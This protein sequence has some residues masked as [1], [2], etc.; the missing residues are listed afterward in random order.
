[1]K[2]LEGFTPG[3]LINCAVA[4][5]IHY[6]LISVL[7]LVSRNFFPQKYILFLSNYCCIFSIPC[8]WLFFRY[9]NHGVLDVAEI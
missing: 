7:S 4:N 6:I 8:H 5:I 1:M 3:I 2:T 9:N